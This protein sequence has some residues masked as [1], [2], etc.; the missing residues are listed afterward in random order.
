MKTV[1]LPEYVKGIAHRYAKDFVEEVDGIRE[2]NPKYEKAFDRAVNSFCKEYYESLTGIKANPTTPKAAAAFDQF[3][4]FFQGF[5]SARSG[6]PDA[7]LMLTRRLKSAVMHLAHIYLEYEGKIAVKRRD[8][9]L[10]DFEYGSRQ[11][12]PEDKTRNSEAAVHRYKRIFVVCAILASLE[13]VFRLNFHDIE[14]YIGAWMEDLAPGQV[15]QT[16]TQNTFAGDVAELFRA[17]YS[18]INLVKR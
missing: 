6:N 11:G 4:P 10:S 2:S 5:I 18:K 14:R 9:L 1:Y 8:S 12:T 15:N 7:G 13:S 17:Q 3:N 16:H